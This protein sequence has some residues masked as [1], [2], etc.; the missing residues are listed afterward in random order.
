MQVVCVYRSLCGIALTIL[1]FLAGPQL[2]KHIRRCQRLDKQRMHFTDACKLNLFYAVGSVREY[3][4]IQEKQ[5]SK[6]VHEIHHQ[7]GA[8]LMASCWIWG[9]RKIQLIVI[10]VNMNAQRNVD[11]APGCVAFPFIQQQSLETLL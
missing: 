8:H 7:G 9:D 4:R 3:R 1:H 5:V 2:A 6:C 10:R 11:D